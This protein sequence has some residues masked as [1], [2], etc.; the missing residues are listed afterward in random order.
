MFMLKF[1]AVVEG[2]PYAGVNVNEM[3]QPGSSEA[4]HEEPQLTLSTEQRCIPDLPCSTVVHTQVQVTTTVRKLSIECFEPTEST[5]KQK[6]WKCSEKKRNGCAITYDCIEAHPGQSVLVT[7]TT[8]H[9]HSPKRTFE[10]WYKVEDIKGRISQGSPGFSISVEGPSRFLTVSVPPGPNINTRL[11]YDQLYE[12]AELESSVF[13][14]IDTSHSL[15]AN[16]SFPYMLPCLCVEV[17]STE[18][19]APRTK[20]CPFKNKPLAGGRDIWLS[21]SDAM[22]DQTLVLKPV[23]VSASLMPS[24]SLCW[25][26]Q[27]GSL[28]C[29]PVANSTLQVENWD[30]LVGF[31]YNVSTVDQ[32]PQMCVQFSLNGTY[33]VRCPFRLGHSKWQAVILP[34]AW[35]FHVRLTSSVPASFSVQL[36]V[37]EGER[38]VARGAVHSVK[39]ENTAETDLWLPFSTVSAG[40]CVQVW[41]STPVL[42]GRR[43]LCPHSSHG[44]LGL[45]AV[46]SVVLVVLM[47]TLACLAYCAVRRGLSDWQLRQKPVLL[48]CSSEQMPQVSAVCAL[49]SLLQGELC[50]GVR[51]ALWAQN[52]G[53]VTKLG[54]L[55]WLYGQCEAVRSAGGRVLI[56]WSPEA[57][58]AYC[59]WKKDGEREKSE[60]EKKH[61]E[62]RGED[63]RNNDLVV[64]EMAKIHNENRIGPASQSDGQR[65]PSSVTVPILRAALACLQCDLLGGREGHGF[66][67]VYFEGLSHSHDI[68]PELRGVPRYCLPQDFGGLVRELQGGTV[69]GWERKGCPCWAGLLSKILALRLAQRLRT[70][71]PQTWPPEEE[72]KGTVKLPWEPE[73]GERPFRL[74]RLPLSW[75]FRE[76]T[77]QTARGRRKD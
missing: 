16:L 49:A 59:C 8:Y 47:M 71:L 55:P 77:E 20:D 13:H 43:L 60:V 5:V 7:V 17:Y 27:E 10:R 31:Q 36:C 66:A 22:Y 21:S 75:I 65:E 40:L 74:A 29:L 76:R 19:D 25:Q 11:C 9:K 26:V 28:H 68:P 69:G 48:V 34:A 6:H 24:A 54:P 1:V 38:C 63:V 46:A 2:I 37:L 57:G 67:L 4:D 72:M 12:C 3:V 56:A 64:E 41:R 50:A 23:C 42:I 61:G 39:T 62:D 35:H 33:D 14:R 70:W 53:G 32:H 52:T 30:R 15:T 18:L 51:M 44:R 45:I 73:R 58:E